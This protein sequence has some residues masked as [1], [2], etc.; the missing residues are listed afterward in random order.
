MNWI[1]GIA[2][3]IFIY[4]VFFRKSENRATIQK[5]VPDEIVICVER[6]D[7]PDA[8]KIDPGNAE[9]EKDNWEKFDYCNA[10]L[11]PA[12]GNY[13]IIYEDQ[14]GLKTERDIKVNLNP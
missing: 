4:F 7:T 11:L 13:K 12:K 5:H 1:I 2:F 8:R 14:S 3:A 10:R 6:S 9:E